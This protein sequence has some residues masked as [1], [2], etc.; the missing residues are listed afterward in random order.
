MF[1]NSIQSNSNRLKMCVI[2]IGASSKIIQLRTILTNKSAGQVSRMGW[3][4]A[5]Y[6][7]LGTFVLLKEIS[8]L[9]ILFLQLVSSPIY[10]K[11]KT[12]VWWPIYSLVSSWIFPLLLLVQYIPMVLDRSRQ[13]IAN[14]RQHKYL[15]YT[16]TRRNNGY[17]H[18]C[19]EW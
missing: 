18:D 19:D 10:S 9:L 8:L 15:R 17:M 12:W 1:L 7:N 14:R 13:M 6:S 4:I 3:A 16:H 2:P 5:S 11:Q